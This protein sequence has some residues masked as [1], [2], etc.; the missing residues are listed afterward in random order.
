LILPPPP[1][2]QHL[3]IAVK[4]VFGVNEYPPQPV[5]ASV[6]PAVGVN[7]VTPPN[8]GLI[9]TNGVILVSLIVIV[10]LVATTTP[11]VLTVRTDTVKV[12]APSVVESAAAV[13][14]NDPVLVLMLNEPLTALKSASAVVMLLIVQ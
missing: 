4:L 11:V 9:V 1:A 6:A 3:T 14:L 8:A 5:D 12:W 13:I 10:S 7:D 2:P